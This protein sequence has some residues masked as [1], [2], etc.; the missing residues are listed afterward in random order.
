MERLVQVIGQLPG[1]I[2]PQQIRPTGILI[3]Q[4]ISA[5]QGQGFLALFFIEQQQGDVFGRVA[6]CVQGPQGHIA[7]GN[8][9]A[10]RHLRQ[11][12][13][14]GVA[15][16]AVNSSSR[17]GVQFMRP[18]YKIGVDMGFNDGGDAHPQF[19][20]FVQINGHIP[21]RVNDGGQSGFIVAHQV[22]QLSQPFAVNLFEYECHNF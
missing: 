22:A 20:R 6:R 18:R 21:A 17:P 3:E 4:R 19:L 13:L 16:A 8:L 11:R 10:I 12:E 2:L 14:I 9:V 15:F 1:N 5:K 7:Q